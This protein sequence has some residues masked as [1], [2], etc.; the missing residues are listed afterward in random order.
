MTLPTKLLI[1]YT[2]QEAPQ[3][4]NRQ[5]RTMSWSRYQWQ[6]VVKVSTLPAIRKDG[7]GLDAGAGLMQRTL[8][9]CCLEEYERDERPEK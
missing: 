2:V 4:I 7:A 1:P 8:D 3:D 6:Q 5:Q 9:V